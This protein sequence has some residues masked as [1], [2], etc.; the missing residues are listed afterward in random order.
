MSAVVFLKK[1]LTSTAC[2]GLIVLSTGCATDNLTQTETGQADLSLTAEPSGAPPA[3]GQASPK[4]DAI[5]TK[6]DVKPSPSQVSFKKIY[7]KYHTRTKASSN[8]DKPE[9]DRFA[10]AEE[11]NRELVKL[12]RK[13]H[14]GSP[15]LRLHSV[16]FPGECQD[17]KP[18]RVSL[19]GKKLKPLS[20]RQAKA[21]LG[22][23]NARIRSFF[24]NRSIMGAKER[25]NARHALQQPSH[26]VVNG[27]A[28]ISPCG[29]KFSGF[30]NAASQISGP[31]RKSQFSALITQAALRHNVDEKLVHA[32]IQTE[33]AYNASAK[34]PAGA[35][36]LMQLMPE[37]AKRYGVVDRS[38]PDQNI[39]GGTRYLKY[40]LGLF[41]YNLDLAV[42]AYNAGENAV[43]RYN[44]SIPPYPETQ[45]YVRQ[46]LSIYNRRI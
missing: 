25:F 4:P 2:I 31:I 3:N 46:V 6:S 36:G 30:A 26:G 45:N 18:V 35:V 34:S 13:N 29:P 32:V 27:M 43:K 5:D 40:L 37:T 42:A 22:K 41:N 1:Q 44:Y 33:S 20:T 23:A 10:S 39:N 14:L 21:H 24:Y 19:S 17:N 7:E 38:N 28:P 15:S 12:Y 9:N 8:A 16:I 11:I